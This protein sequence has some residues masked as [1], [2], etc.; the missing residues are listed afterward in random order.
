MGKHQARLMK[1]VLDY[2]GWHNFTDSNPSAKNA[3]QSLHR[4][5]LVKLEFG[6]K[7]ISRFCRAADTLT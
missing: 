4:N 5:G 2:P 3:L 7:G 6:K 1:F